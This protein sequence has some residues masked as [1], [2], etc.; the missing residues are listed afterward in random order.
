MA[1]ARRDALHHTYGEYLTWPDDEPYELI[2]GIAYVKEPPSPLPLHQH[3]VGE[4]YFQLRLAL[5]GKPYRPY[6]APLDVRLPRSAE[7]DEQV[8][9][10]V[11]PDVFVVRDLGKFDERGM[12]GAPEWLAEILSPSTASY[13]QIVKLPI[14]ERSGVGEAWLVHPVRRE[15]T[16]YRLEAGRYRIPVTLELK[17]RTAISAIP[18]VS[19]DWDRMLTRLTC[20]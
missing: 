2:D 10:I 9:T 12:R 13:D 16:I 20:V 4:L 6:I 5:D 15:V 17:G 8:D 14:Y 1:L 19:I 18:G 7:A 3:L 11:Q